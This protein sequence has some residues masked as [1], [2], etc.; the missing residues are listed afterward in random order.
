[1][2]DQN[3]SSKRAN[4]VQK[5]KIINE[6]T[7]AQGSINLHDELNIIVDVHT[8]VTPTTRHSIP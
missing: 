4:F 5:F 2:D 8:P 6:S 3:A 7:T 1:M